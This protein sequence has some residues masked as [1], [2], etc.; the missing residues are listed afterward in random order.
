MDIKSTEVAIVGGGQAGLALS[1]RLTEQG[2]PHVILE[3]RRLVESW[4]TKRWDSLR[5]IAPNWS[6]VLPGFAY[7]GDE[8]DGFM[9]RDDVVQHLVGYAGSFGAPVLEGTRVSSVERDSVKERFLL[10]TQYGTLEADRVVLA[11]GAL[12]QPKLPPDAK[13]L[14]ST[15]SQLVAADY[16]NPGMLERGGVLIVG[17]G[18]TGCQVAEELARAG[19]DVYLSGGRSWWAP[20]RYRGRDIAAWLRLTGWFERRAEDL[21]PGAHAGQPNPQLTGAG[22]GH[23]INAHSLA[24]DG[25]RLLGRLRGIS[26]GTAFFSDDLPANVSWADAQARKLLESIDHVIATQGLDAPSADLPA[27][28]LPVGHGLAP[29]AD[30]DPSPPAELH[31][32]NARISTV[33]WATGYRPDFSWVRLPFIDADGYPIQRRGVTS[34]EGLYVLGLDWLH[35][36]KSGLFAGIGDDATHLASVITSPRRSARSSRADP[37]PACRRSSGRASSD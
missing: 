16:R 7:P 21:P 10:R 18:E 15:I 19:R 11:T 36:A 2:R 30:G 14:P 12:Q 22:G 4:R 17:S 29:S 6:M 32:G 9:G 5:L 20:R 3:Q 34:V 13:A 24:R 1:Y 8:P 31:L 26:E 27:D 37:S 28:L 23:D 25:V 35:N 33:I